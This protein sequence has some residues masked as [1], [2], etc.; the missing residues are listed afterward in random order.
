VNVNWKKEIVEEYVNEILK[1]EW[2]SSYA[3]IF[4]VREEEYVNVTTS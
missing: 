4:E 1:I 2:K 3:N